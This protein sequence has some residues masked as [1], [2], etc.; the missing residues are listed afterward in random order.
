MS[1]I[2]RRDFLKS[3][4]IIGSVPLLYPSFVH[5]MNLA[6]PQT[7]RR[8]VVIILRGGMDSLSAVIPY[9][10]QEYYKVRRNL[11]VD[12]DK[13]LR[14]DNYFSLH[15]SLDVFHNLYRNRELSVIHST[16]LPYRNR[17]HFDLQNVL[18]LG[19]TRPNSLR[20][21]WLN[22][23]I[24]EI[25]SSN[26]NLGLSLGQIVPLIM[27]G[28]NKVSSWAPSALPKMNRDLTSLVKK[29]YGNDQLF[30]DNFAE[31]IKVKNKAGSMIS[32][33][34]EEKMTARSR[35]PQSI[36]VMSRMAGKWLSEQDGPR[37]ATLEMDGWDTHAA[38]GSIDGKLSNNFKT[39]TKAI[40]AL[41]ESLGSTWNKTTI[42]TMTEFGRTVAMNGTNG[43]DHGTA[44]CMFVL[45]GAVNGGKILSDWP[46]LEKS[47]LYEGRDLMPTTDSRSVLKG[48]LRDL[49]GINNRILDNN[50]FPDSY[51]AKAID[52]LIKI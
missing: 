41:K 47:R 33:K 26:S 30:R 40:N 23:L 46:G 51:N 19:S 37:I 43:T 52:K 13:V 38:Q 45:G 29:I 3:S 48:I 42:V 50:I 22:R 5:G 8:L 15:P 27:R 49:Y 34:R 9:A 7:D 10:D 39:L 11:A 28:D 36:I 24:G 20:D 16:A 4:A 18:E 32:S 1:K 17:S 31:A 2:N 14:L 12:S 35:S 25:D 21:G 44:S 6:K